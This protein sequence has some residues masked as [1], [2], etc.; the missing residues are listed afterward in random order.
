MSDDLQSTLRAGV[1]AAKRGDRTTARRLLEEVIAADDNNELAWLWLASAVTSVAER[2]T[3]LERVLQINPDNARAREALEKLGAGQPT[4]AAAAESARVRETIN[5]VRQTQAPRASLD[6][7][8]TTTTDARSPLIT[9][10]IVGGLIGVIA[11]IGAFAVNVLTPPPTPTL[12]PTEVV[13]VST[14][15]PTPAAT[16]TPT[17]TNTPLDPSQIT[18]VAGRTLPP[19]FTPTFTPSPTRTLEPSPTPLGLA[20]FTLFYVSL[21]TGAP[22]PDVYN[23]LGDSSNEGLQFDFSR[24]VAF[25]PTGARIAFIRDVDVA[26]VLVPEV[27]TASSDDPNSA[28]QIT[29]LGV[30]DTASPSWSPDGTQIAFA[31][32]A[33]S[34]STEIWLMNADGGS[35]RK[36]T[37]NTVA[38]REPAFS[39]VTPL[40]AY[41][42]DQD[43]PG[44]V[45]ELYLMTLNPDATVSTQRLTDA[46]G[47]S[48][49]PSWSQNGRLMV[50]ASDRDGAG[51]IYVMDAGL[52]GSERLVTYDGRE[53][54]NRRPA[55]S[56]DGRWIAYASNRD[57]ANFQTYLTDPQ[58]LEVIRLVDNGRDDF[59]AVF[60]PVAS[61][62]LLTATP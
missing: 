55:I 36:L 61:D 24:D 4:V 54:E 6:L 25:D 35:L 19:L 8:S 18:R 52:V 59:N 10:L 45:T 23:I 48:Y 42:T 13:I 41:T 44:T 57:S 40:I 37:D 33:D 49:S 15:S 60:R 39:P 17:Q 12:T 7:P 1:D 16:L 53:V 58:G 29:T 3:C 9:L 21:N 22:Q 47:S 62:L 43:S 28:V 50:F 5:R 32:G 30:P 31:S 56:P 46:A 14:E 34:V 51:D 27:F 38:D 20:S 26:G 2:R 11:I